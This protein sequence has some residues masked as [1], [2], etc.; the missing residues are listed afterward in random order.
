MFT[1]IVD[2]IKIP[3][4]KDDLHLSLGRSPENNIICHDK[5]ASRRHVELRQVNGVLEIRDLNSTNGTRVNRIKLPPMVWQ[6]L[7]PGQEIRVG[8]YI[9]RVELTLEKS[10]VRP[11]SRRG[12]RPGA[13]A[14]APRPVI[15]S[16]RPSESTSG[17]VTNSRPQEGTSGGTGQPAP[18]PTE[19][20]AGKSDQPE[21]TPL[22]DIEAPLEPEPLQAGTPGPP[23][24]TESQGEPGIDF[25]PAPKMAS[26]PEPKLFVANTLLDN[27]MMARVEHLPDGSVELAQVLKR[28]PWS[29]GDM[30]LE[31]LGIDTNGRRMLGKVQRFSQ[32]EYENFLESLTPP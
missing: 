28:V 18:R 10:P 11:R 23:P 2:D 29:Q 16:L 14:P 9:M 5:A 24:D 31:L 13:A 30:G 1:L 3:L 19:G 21:L 8:D 4:P 25:L 26:T 6:R 20:T 27:G 32:T 15:P 22:P 7:A 12:T 17:R